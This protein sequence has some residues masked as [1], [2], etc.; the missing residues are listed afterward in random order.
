M[1]FDILP[2][3][4]QT[5][6]ADFIAGIAFDRQAAEWEYYEKSS[7]R[8]ALYLRPILLAVD[9]ESSKPNGLVMELAHCLRYYYQSGNSPRNLVDSLTQKI[10]E[11]ILQRDL[12]LLQK[13]DESLA[14]H[15]SR[16][17]Y[18][19]YKKMYHQLGWLF[20]NNSVS[21][22]S[23]DDD[24]VPDELVDQAD[25]ISKKFGYEKIPA[26]CDER[27]KQALSELESAWKQ[28]NHRIDDGHN[29]GIQVHIDDEDISTWK[30]SYDSE[31]TEEPTFFDG[32]SQID[33]ADIMKFV[34]DQLEIWPVF[35]PLKY[36]YIK[37]KQPD[38]LALVA[39]SLADAFGF[40]VKKMSEMSNANYNYLRTIDENFMHTENLNNT[41]DVTSNYI[42][43]LPISR[44]WD[45]EDNLIIADADGQK[46]ETSQ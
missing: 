26:Y 24:L 4:K 5:V 42:H 18:Y 27:L 30:L 14:I 16:L 20:C 41:N 3:E 33:I 40:G 1:G 38:P 45:I 29:T 17:E 12:K 11:K 23:L 37:H 34:G 32:L 43:R 44:T 28:T 22:C 13:K 7:R 39:C 15:P 31:K 9:F 2:K 46:F 6:M 35:N 10:I 21:Y 25:E 36:R 8:M 19:L